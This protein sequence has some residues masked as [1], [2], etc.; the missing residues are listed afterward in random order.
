MYVERYSK[1]LHF[2]AIR[3]LISW[4][5]EG[6]RTDF[7]LVYVA[8]QQYLMKLLAECVVKYCRPGFNCVASKKIAFLGFL[9]KMQIR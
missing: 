2:S 9:G 3:R 6:C 8:Q 5:L 1:T 4:Y 7:F